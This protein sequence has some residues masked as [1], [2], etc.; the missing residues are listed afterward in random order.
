MEE[1]GT[2][3][4]DDGS[5][6]SSSSDRRRYRS[7]ASTNQGSYRSVVD[8]DTEEQLFEALM[9][10]LDDDVEHNQSCSAQMT[11]LLTDIRGGEPVQKV[12]F[13]SDWTPKLRGIFHLLNLY[14]CAYCCRLQE[15]QNF[16]RN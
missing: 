13:R 8:Y 15:R 7:A 5:A 10:F 1:C 16:K 9:L 14:L 4:S 11:S 3:I 6:S 2:T 12:S